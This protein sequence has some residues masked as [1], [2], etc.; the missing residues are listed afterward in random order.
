M[1]ANVSAMD[2]TTPLSITTPKYYNQFRSIQLVLVKITNPYIFTISCLGLITNTSTIALLSKSFLTKNLRHK[3]TL[4][5]LGTSDRRRLACHRWTR[6]SER[7]MSFTPCVVL[8]ALSDLMLNIAL[9]IRVIRDVNKWQTQRLCEAIS[10]LSH[11]AEILSA[12]F[13]VLFTIQRYV[14]VRYPFQVAIQKRSS[15]LIPLVVILILSVIFCLALRRSN[16]VDNHCLEDLTLGWF[17]ADALCS[18]IVPF[19]LILLF[20]LLIVELIRKHSRSSITANSTLP[21]NVAHNKDTTRGKSG[22]NGERNSMTYSYAYSPTSNGPLPDDDIDRHL[23]SS[24]SLGK[25]AGSLP[26][27]KKK[28]SVVFHNGSDEVEC[29]ANDLLVN[30]VSVGVDWSQLNVV[31]LHLC[32]H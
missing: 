12:F 18:F 4:I 27:I 7:S 10:F 22:T 17:I 23:D 31:H 16:D 15:P 19:S 32:K 24:N 28:E 5:A 29:L 14:A 26:S 2:F 8:L 30:I 6:F 21:R 9:L 11:L 1:I 13:T 20:N 3:W 25:L